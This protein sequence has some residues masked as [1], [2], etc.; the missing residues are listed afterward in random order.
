MKLELSIVICTV[1]P[2]LKILNEVLNSINSQSLAKTSWELIIVDNN[3]STP[4]E[5]QVDITWQKNAKVIT[6][7]KV[8]LSYARIAG[9]IA[10]KTDLIVFV[11]DDNIL[12]KDYLS[13]SLLYKNKFSK[14]GCFGGKSIPVFE[15]APAD[16]FFSSGINLGC[17]DLGDNQ[18]ISSYNKLNYNISSYPEFAPIGTGMVITKKAFLVYHNE[19]KN[20]KIRLALGR[21][22]KL[23]TSGED[24]DIILTIIK[25]GFEIGYFP[26]LK[27]NH[28]IPK[29]RLNLMYLKKMAFESNRSWVKVLQI[30]EINPWKPISKIG[31]FLRLIRAIIRY[32]PWVDEKHQLELQTNLGK[33]KGLSEI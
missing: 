25:N 16:W 14:L 24:N 27:I 18:Y 3:S 23:L 32:K 31:F 8:G 7:S 6:E 11:D 4:I 33:L 1:N 30:H 22:G 5:S 29:S 28:F 9:V 10:S 20:S 13:F 15:E 26:D 19:V 21:K 17:Q 2:D 12:S